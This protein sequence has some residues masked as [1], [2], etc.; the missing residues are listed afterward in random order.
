MEVSVRELKNHLSTYLRRMQAGEVVIVTSRGKPLAQ[1]TPVSV[2]PEE[3]EAAAI[4]RL[5]AQPW[6]RRGTGDKPT[7]ARTP[8][9]WKRGQKK[10]SDLV[11]AD[12]E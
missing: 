9:P 2:T 11:L 8:I 10:L 3:T 1:L 7:G 12:R 6:V 5:R 4:E